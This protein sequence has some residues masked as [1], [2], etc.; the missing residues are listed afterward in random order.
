M[1]EKTEGTIKNWQSSILTTC[2]IRDNQ[3]HNQEWA[4]HIL[5]IITAE[6]IQN[7]M[8]HKTKGNLPN[9]FNCYSVTSLFNVY[10]KW[11]NG[12]YGR[13]HKDDQ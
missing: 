10:F 7:S 1:L 5:T 9:L 13:Q 2:I 11:E 3:R 12:W 6:D 8:L 4:I